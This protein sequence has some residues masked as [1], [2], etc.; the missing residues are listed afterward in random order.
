M[1]ATAKLIDLV[2]GKLSDQLA[3][4]YL[5][6]MSNEEPNAAALND[7]IISIRE[8]NKEN[9]ILSSTNEFLAQSDIEKDIK[10]IQK[11]IIDC[12]GTGGS[13][14]PHYNT[15]TS[16]SFVLAAG[17]LKVAKFGNRAASGV[18][19]SFDF[20]EYL[21]FPVILSS[22]AID[23]ILDILDILQTTN[24][25]FLFAP[26][27]YPSLARL[28]S[29]RKSLGKPTL[30]NLVGPLL[31]PLRPSFRIIGTPK[32]DAQKAIA[33]YLFLYKACTKALV[34]RADSGLDELDPTAR[35]EILSIDRQSINSSYLDLSIKADSRLNGPLLT[36]KENAIIFN[37]MI[38]GTLSCTDYYVNS[39][40]LNAGAG[41]FIAGK[42]S[43]IEEGQKLANNLLSSGTVLA[44]YEQCRN[45]Y[46]KYT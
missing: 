21:G 16:V 35:N 46:A 20:L 25:C 4:E 31:N 39:V 36:A 38:R 11:D 17:G 34:V 9:S 40:T 22:E 32:T 33:D 44:K 5:L 10:N 41:F 15:S 6:E 43:S 23:D 26:H 30:F 12:C 18:S 45:M 37:K 19:G 27:F 14:M 24:L 28:S 2:S 1:L 29:I 42:S 13:G 8:A 3:Y 7:L